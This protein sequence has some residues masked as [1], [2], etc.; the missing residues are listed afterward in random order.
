MEQGNKVV[1]E[2]KPSSMRSLSAWL[3]Y[4]QTIKQKWP[5]GVFSRE[6]V[7]RHC[8]ANDLWVVL[9]GRVFDITPYLEFHPGGAEILLE[10][11]GQDVT[12]PFS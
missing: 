12:V 1:L 6:E 8:T 3:G 2:S 5:L 9:C 10:Y 11:A 7:R 4:K